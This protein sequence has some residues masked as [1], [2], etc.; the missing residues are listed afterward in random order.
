M[1]VAA[2]GYLLT[3]AVCAGVL[4]AFA[5]T[6]DE[7]AGVM[8]ILLWPWLFAICVLAAV[9]NLSRLATGRLISR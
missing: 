3:G 2:A 7:G 5:G 8:C 9:A 1:I 6:D 4:Q